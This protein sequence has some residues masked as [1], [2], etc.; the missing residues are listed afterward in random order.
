MLA[1]RSVWPAA[2]ERMDRNGPTAAAAP[3][4]CR[5]RLRERGVWAMS[6]SVAVLRGNPQ[7]FRET[8]VFID[9]P[10]WFR[11]DGRD[12]RRTSTRG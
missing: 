3:T 2:R 9:P 5:K 1:W 6:W 7:C 12:R 11:V 10:A 4:V 8:P